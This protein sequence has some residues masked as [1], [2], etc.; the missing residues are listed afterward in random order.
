MNLSEF[1]SGQCVRMEENGR[2]YHEHLP[3]RLPPRFIKTGSS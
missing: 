2:K 3:P 1:H